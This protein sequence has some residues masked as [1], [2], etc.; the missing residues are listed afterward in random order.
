[1]ATHQNSTLEHPHKHNSEVLD[2]TFYKAL[3]QLAN[4]GIMLLQN[5]RFL[6]CNQRM[7]ELIGRRREE[8]IGYTPWDISPTHQ[9]DGQDSINKARDFIKRG[10]AGERLLF[11]WLHSRNDGTQ[12]T[13]EISLAK[14]SYKHHGALLCHMR[15]ISKR[16]LIEAALRKSEEQYRRVVQD[17]LDFIVRWLPDGTR[18]FISDSYCDYF[19]QSKEEIIGTSFYPLIPPD[20][21]AKVKARINALTPDKPVSTGEHLVITP[22][23]EKR[24]QH[25]VDRAFFDKNG[26]VTE[27]Q[28]V[29]RDIHDKK[30]AEE[31]IRISEEK[32]SKAFRCSPEAIMITNAKD[33]RIIEV[34]EGFERNTGYLASD[35]IGRTTLGLGLWADSRQRRTLLKALNKKGYI[36]DLEIQVRIK[37]GELRDCFTSA[38]LIEINH[39]QCLVSVT[40]DH[41]E[42]KKFTA[43]LEHQATHDALTGLHSR[44]LISH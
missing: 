12:I 7:L 13:F 15:D 31:A 27:L 43:E 10:L 28:S 25:W 14:I 38:E 19:Q 26:N 36:K 6:D 9:P 40:R 35:A 32:Y 29:G 2:N 16:K 44:P 17:Q 24:W 3:Y 37:S 33:G 21:Q 34:N 20:Q 8:V 4:D 1:M 5:E 18:T 39:E 23:G 41:T 11:E 30:M 42:N 22:L